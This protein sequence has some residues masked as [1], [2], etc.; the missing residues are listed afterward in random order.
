MIG[1][2]IANCFS[3]IHS[4]ELSETYYQG[5]LNTFRQFSN[6][7]IWFGDSG[8]VLA[9]MIKNMNEPITF[10]LD[11]HLSD[12]STAKGESNTPI[13]KELECIKNHPIKTHT[14][15]ID[16]VR[17]FGTAE[18]DF[19][20]LDVIIQKLKEINP[21]YIISIADAWPYPQDILVAQPPKK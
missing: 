6:V 13:L 12:P 3:E 20:T 18:F 2:Q 1:A 5:A 15:L 9:D 11:G 19:I 21:S 7:H 4:V 8:I 16:D 14:I 17:L 10:W